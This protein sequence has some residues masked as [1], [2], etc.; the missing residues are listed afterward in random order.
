[1]RDATFIMAGHWSAGHSS[2]LSQLGCIMHISGILAWAFVAN[3]DIGASDDGRYP[4]HTD[5]E[6]SI[7]VDIIPRTP[8]ANI[9]P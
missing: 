1:M 3:D 4:R 2:A 5:W 7:F 6:L 8:V 9:P